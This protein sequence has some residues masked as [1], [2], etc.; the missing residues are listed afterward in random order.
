MPIGGESTSAALRRTEAERDGLHAQ[1]GKAIAANGE[2][3][4]ERTKMHTQVVKLTGELAL[5]R[6][7]PL[8]VA[9]EGGRDCL[10]CGLE[11]RRGEAY[12]LRGDLGP[13]QLEHVHCRDKKP[14]PWRRR[15][16]EATDRRIAMHYANGQS[17]VALA[18]DFGT[19][20]TQILKAIRR[21]G[22]TVRND[23]GRRP[24]NTT[25]E[26]APTA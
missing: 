1:L 21:A 18:R 15:F 22:G 2:L 12:E 25:P 23:R 7:R 24:K 9:R 13:D 19:D 26:G 11:I 14:R 10:R 16:D 3:F 20:S 5:L 6:Q 17:S 8:L 4:D